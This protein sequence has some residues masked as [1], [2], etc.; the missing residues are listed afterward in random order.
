MSG[1]NSTNWKNRIVR[2][3]A[4]LLVI[5]IL[6]TSPNWSVAADCPDFESTRLVLGQAAPCDGLLL[7][8]S[9]AVKLA[10]K[11]KGYNELLDSFQ[12]LSYTQQLTAQA[13][14]EC[15][16]AKVETIPWYKSTPVIVIEVILGFVAGGAAGYGLFKLIEGR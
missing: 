4:L 8:E 11:A 14:E 3:T 16:A 13:L 9:A 2:I 1:Q 5:T 7:S 15:N 10:A 6:L 12:K